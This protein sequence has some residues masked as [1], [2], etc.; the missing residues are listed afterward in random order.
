MSEALDDVLKGDDP[1]KVLDATTDEGVVPTHRAADKAMV[2][3]AVS[4]WS[5]AKYM[6]AWKNDRPCEKLQA[7]WALEFSS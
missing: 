4:A 3:E 5:A 1:G 6:G 2:K 7:D